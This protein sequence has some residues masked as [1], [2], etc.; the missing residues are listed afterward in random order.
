MEKKF[1]KAPHLRKSLPEMGE[2]LRS[3]QQFTRNG[4]KIRKV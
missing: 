2:S 4:S 3:Y 1:V